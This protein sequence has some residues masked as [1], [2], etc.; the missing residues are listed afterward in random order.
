MTGNIAVF[1]VNSLLLGL[2]L[3]L[4][5]FSICITNALI[6]HKMARKR[7]A[8]IAL[9]HAAFQM[10]MTYAGYILVKILS[11]IFLNFLKVVPYIALTLLSYIGI[12]MIIEGIKDRRK[13]REDKEVKEDNKEGRRK[14]GIKTL[15]LQGVAASIDAL[16]V[17]CALGMYSAARLFTASFTIGLTTFILCLLAFMLGERIP[18]KYSYNANIAGGTVLVAIGLEIVLGGLG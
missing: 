17:G 11:T 10:G 7:I 9:M 14:I 8:F 18:I 12:K 4:D 6:E 3:S 1:I 15:L 13:A 2:S 16:S 5:S